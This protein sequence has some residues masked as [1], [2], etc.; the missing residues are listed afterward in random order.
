MNNKTKKGFTLVE[1]LVV[2]S[3]IGVLATLVIANMNSA[4]ERARD[5]QRK[6]D[7]RNIQTALRLYY[8]DNGGYPTSS[9][10]NIVGCD[11][12][13]VWGE[14]WVN[15]D[16]TYMNILPDDPLSNQIYKY[17]YIDDDDY[18][19]EACLE[20]VSDDKGIATTDLDWCPTGWKYE[21]K[22]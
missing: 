16:V 3:L 21:V 9:T 2:V 22:P 12:N 17:T 11:G 18:I 13:C 8:N 6:S 1:L 14:S 20:N 15:D 4:R 7:F 10:D 19:L 5:T